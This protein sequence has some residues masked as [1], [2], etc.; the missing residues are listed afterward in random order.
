MSALLTKIRSKGH[1]EVVIRPHKFNKLKLPDI[2]SLYPLLQKTS[3]QLRGWDFP[4]LD[5]NTPPHIDIDWV[6]QECNYGDILEIWRF[7]R[8]GQFIHI[9]G[10]RYDWTD[11]QLLAH[12][13]FKSPTLPVL[14]I[15]DTL[16][17]LTEIFEFASRLALTE[18]GDGQMH[19]Q[20]ILNGLTGRS[21]WVD[22]QNRMQFVQRHTAE[23]DKFPYEI[24]VS[25]TKLIAEP[26]DLAIEAAI[27][28]FRRF[29]WNPT[30]EQLRGQQ[31]DLKR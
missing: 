5:W 14:G 3:V 9:S 1:W 24:E 21:L 31:S 8:S 26:R 27:E 22:S 10:I 16:F 7:Y 30:P 12:G 23:I 28:L 15:G 13:R 18:A 2:S 25:K 29:G 17:R 11:P 19:L 6:G 4:H 20:I